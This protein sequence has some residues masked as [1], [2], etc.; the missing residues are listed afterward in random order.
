M[1]SSDFIA[2]RSITLTWAFFRLEFEWFRKRVDIAEAGLTPG[3]EFGNAQRLIVVRDEQ[4][5]R[6]IVLG[7]SDFCGFATKHLEVDIG[8]RQH[9]VLYLGG[10]RTIA[11]RHLPK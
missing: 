7:L 2:L 4:G 1:G 5:D 3:Q 8:G 10:Q 6:R 11:D 9:D